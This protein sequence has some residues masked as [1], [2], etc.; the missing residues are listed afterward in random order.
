MKEKQLPHNAIGKYACGCLSKSLLI[1]VAVSEVI[2]GTQLIENIRDA[3]VICSVAFGV[4]QH[5]RIFPAE[6][7]SH[8]LCGEVILNI[9]FILIRYERCIN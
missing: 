1:E 9:Q 8:V 2:K 4:R 3:M 7:T 6:E 5:P